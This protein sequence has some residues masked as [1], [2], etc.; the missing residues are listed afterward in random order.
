MQKTPPRGGVFVCA[1][2]EQAPHLPD[3]GQ[4]LRMIRKQSTNLP[5]LG[6]IGIA[7]FRFKHAQR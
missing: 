5:D 2:F 4:A 7:P 3:A 6:R 1:E